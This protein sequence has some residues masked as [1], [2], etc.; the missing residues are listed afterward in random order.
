MSKSQPVTLTDIFNEVSQAKQKRSRIR[1]LR[2][3]D[4]F[5]LRTILQ[6]NFSPKVDFP[7]PPGEPPYEKN[8]SSV[9]P[10]KELVSILGSCTKSSKFAQIKKETRFISFLESINYNDARLFCLMKDG[11]LEEEFDWLTEELVRE[12]F[13]GLLPEA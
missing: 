6:G 3:F 9:E 12:A 13:P 11:E 5:A 4:T 10:T 2:Q 8:E 7:F 1:K